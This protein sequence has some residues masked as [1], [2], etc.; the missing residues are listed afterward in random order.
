MYNSFLDPQIIREE[1]EVTKPLS[2]IDSSEDS[3]TLMVQSVSE[4]QTCRICFT[5]GH[6]LVDIF[7]IDTD[8]INFYMK[9]R[10]CFV[11]LVSIYTNFIM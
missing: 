3:A 7:Q 9:Y 8:D 1:L 5:S 4:L 11:D 6:N 2:E 10:I